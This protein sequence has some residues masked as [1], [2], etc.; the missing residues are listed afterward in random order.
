M[1]LTFIKERKLAGI[2]AA[3]VKWVYKGRKKSI[4][5]EAVQRD[6]APIFYPA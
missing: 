6:I 4:D 1:E 5:R 2:E 3:K